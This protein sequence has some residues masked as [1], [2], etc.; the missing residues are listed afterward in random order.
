MAGYDMS[1]ASN[2]PAAAAVEVPTGLPPAP[3]GMSSRSEGAPAPESVIDTD[4]PNNDPAADGQQ[5]G[6]DLGAEPPALPFAP[7]VAEF[8]TALGF[9]PAA[10]TDPRAIETMQALHAARLEQVESAMRQTIEQMREPVPQEQQQVEEAPVVLSPM[11]QVQAD[12]SAALQNLCALNGV[13]TEQELAE[14]NPAM[15]Q[16]LANAYNSSLRDAQ[17]EEIQWIHSTELQ[18]IE[19]SRQ[20]QARQEYALNVQAHAEGNLTNLQRE[21][22]ELVSHLVESGMMDHI[23][24]LSGALGVAPEAMLADQSFCSYVAKAAQAIR[25]V[26]N[27]P[28]MIE[29]GVQERIA[30]MRKAGAA[31]TV[32]SDSPVPADV[33]IFARTAGYGRG[34]AL[35]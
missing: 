8:A 9:D 11:Q 6:M 31:Q 2:E 23:E 18:K 1:S 21:N 30:A 27:I 7:E 22:P 12:F 13:S 25:M 14:V 15:Y 19:A 35:V 5:D 20:E 28:A 34:V 4:N 17:V 29:K 24:K 16:N 3:E 33:G 10:I 26:D 32:A